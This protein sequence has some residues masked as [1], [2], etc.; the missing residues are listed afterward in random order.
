MLTPYRLTEDT[1]GAGN[2]QI[3]T[4]RN[5][6][7]ILLTKVLGYSFVLFIKTFL[8][9]KNLAVIWTQRPQ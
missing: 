7:F 4:T 6:N 2:V 9:K 3:F 1:G 5:L 8:H